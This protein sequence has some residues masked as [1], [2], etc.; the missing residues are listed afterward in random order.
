LSSIGADCIFYLH[1]YVSKKI[2]S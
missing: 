1:K 2:S